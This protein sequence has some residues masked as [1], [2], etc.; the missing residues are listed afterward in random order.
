M[1]TI[2]VNGEVNI[3]P[4]LAEFE[5][6]EVLSSDPSRKAVFL[7]LNNKTTGKAA[8]LVADKNPFV[9]DGSVI[10]EWIKDAKLR[11]LA[12][13]DIYGSYE[14]L[15]PEKF[16]AVKSSLIY[17]ATD[18]HILKYRRREVYMIYETADDYKSITKPSIKESLFNL[19]WVYNFLDHKAETDRIVFDD[20]DP[21]IGFMLAP[22]LKWNG[23]DVDNLYLQAIVVRR[24]IMS[25]RELTGEHIPLLENV[26]KQVRRVV[27]EKYGLNPNQIKMYFHYQPSYP[28]LHIHVINIKYEAPGAGMTCIFLDEAIDNLKIWPDFYQ[29]ATLPFVG[30]EGDVLLNKF[31][32][33]KRLNEE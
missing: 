28:H 19:D 10:N 17:P 24:D 3:Q 2:K 14:L 5:F 9:E 13:N 32:E 21:N 11:N 8:I 27:K 33:A 29:R 23:V 12:Q 18:K 4:N 6:K 30:K 15:M 16:N 1:T 22:D 25:V 7:L 26:R 31:R 20:P